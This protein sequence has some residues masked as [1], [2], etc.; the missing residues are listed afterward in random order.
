MRRFTMLMLV[1][2]VGLAVGGAVVIMAVMS[3]DE[4]RAT[5]APP[6]PDPLC[7]GMLPRLQAADRAIE[8]LEIKLQSPSTLEGAQKEFKELQRM[9]HQYLQIRSRAAAFGC[10]EN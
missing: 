6:S 2:L 5:S 7:A 8:R 1:L 9:R 4:R 10:L 3:P